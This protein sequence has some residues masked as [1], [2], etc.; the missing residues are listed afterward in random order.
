[1]SNN[2][3]TMEFLGIDGWNRPVYK[4]VETGTLWKDIT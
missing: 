4:C 2:I 1:M 3:R